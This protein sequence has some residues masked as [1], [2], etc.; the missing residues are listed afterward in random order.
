MAARLLFERSVYVVVVDVD[1]GGEHPL[2]SFV[3][4]LVIVGV[5]SWFVAAC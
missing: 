2:V 4:V 5:R 3:L 1:A